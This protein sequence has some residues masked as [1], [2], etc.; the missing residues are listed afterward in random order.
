VRQERATHCRAYVWK[1]GGGGSYLQTHTR[2]PALGRTDFSAADAPLDPSAVASLKTPEGL[3][4]EHTPPVH[5]RRPAAPQSL[6]QLSSGF[7]GRLKSR[8]VPLDLGRHPVG[9]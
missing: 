2:T 1:G 7:P 8:G 3:P 6:R 4:R 5:H 9:G